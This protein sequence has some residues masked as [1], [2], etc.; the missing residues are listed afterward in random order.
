MS[1]FQ[2]P[3]QDTVDVLSQAKEAINEILKEPI[4]RNHLNRL[5][6]VLNTEINAL[7]STHGLGKMDINPETPNSKPLTKF[8]GRDIKPAQTIT[9]KNILTEKKTVAAAS[10]KTAKEQEEAELEDNAVELYEQF[11]DIPTDKLFDEFDELVIRAVGVLAGLPYTE[12]HPKKIDIHIIED[13]KNAIK[14]KGEIE[15]V[16][17][18]DDNAQLIDKVAAA[19][20][21]SPFTIADPDALL[22]DASLSAL[23]SA[24]GMEDANAQQ[25]QISEEELQANQQKANQQ[26][27]NA[28][29]SNNSNKQNQ[30]KP[31]NANNRQR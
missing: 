25:K 23:E 24:A 16:G 20:A 4:M 27:G 28:Q 2:K 18:Q 8:F 11:L 30:Q 5:N 7:K 9:P 15:S 1:T 31:Q 3:M 17:K 26:T 21:G 10:F 22:S 19:I 6:R 12:K 14:R 13:I 29:Q